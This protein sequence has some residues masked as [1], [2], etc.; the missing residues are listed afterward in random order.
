M[1]YELFYFKNK[2]YPENDFVFATPS[3]IQDNILDSTR[4]DL[5]IELSLFQSQMNY[6][7]HL[8]FD[9]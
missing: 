1:I 5:N 3:Q 2:G 8:N 9:K 6:F 7:L 4:H